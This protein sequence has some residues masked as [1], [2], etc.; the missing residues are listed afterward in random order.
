MNHESFMLKKTS[1][2]QLFDAQPLPAL[3]PTQAPTHR[4]RRPDGSNMAK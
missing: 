2:N 3:R 4:V 1:K